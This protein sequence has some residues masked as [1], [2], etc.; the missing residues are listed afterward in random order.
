MSGGSLGGVWSIL[1]RDERFD[2]YFTASDYLRKRLDAIRI[3]R[4][5][6][7]EPNIQPTF[8]DIEKSHMLHIRSSYRPFVS[9]ASEYSRVRPYGDGT[10]ALGPSG[11]SVQFR[12]PIYGHFTSDMALHVR[13]GPIGTKN[14]TLVP[15]GSIAAAEAAT[16]P[17]SGQANKLSLR[18]AYCSYPGIR[19]IERAQFVSGETPISEYTRD[20]VV[21][22]SKFFVLNDFY[23]EFDRSMG[24][25]QLRRAE[26]FN[27]NGFIQSMDFYDG[28]QTPK[29]F[30]DTLDMWIP[31][32]FDCC[33]EPSRAIPNDLISNT[34]RCVNI[35]VAPLTRLLQAFS[36][37]GD[38]DQLGGGDEVPLPFSTLKMDM[39]LY[40]NNLYVN[41]EIHDVFA[42]RIGFQLMRIWRNQTI[43]LQKPKDR[44]LLDQLKFPAEYMMV[45]IRDRAN[46]QSFDDWYLMGREKVRTNAN[47]LVFPATVWN[48]NVLPSGMQELVVRTAIEATTFEP[49]IRSLGVTAHGIQIFPEVPIVFYN[50]YLPMRY[51]GTDTLLAAPEDMS[52]WFLPFCLFPGRGQV[53]GYYNLSTARELYITYSGGAI[54]SETPAELFVTMSA[55]TFL[56]RRADGLQL[57]YAI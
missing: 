12:L 35:D 50:S 32:Q 29:F 45:G 47:Q 53:S 44:I 2:Q 25:Q 55:L 18:Y 34:Q 16:P 23:I 21:M 43:P 15:A 11:G 30:Q 52:C 5:E 28:A 37:L 19:L 7:G 6:K 54:S 10:A 46:A 3:I 26:F 20:D 27:S 57:R 48:P 42:S 17:V 14:P 22:W 41:P 39:S 24:Q 56:M 38:P 8:A 1:V 4:A 13:I 9:I 31:I 51:I 36:Q 49:I 33:R 40:V